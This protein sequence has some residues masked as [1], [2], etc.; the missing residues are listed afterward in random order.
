MRIVMIGNGVAATTAAATIRRY[1]TESS[2]TM[3][4]DESTPFYSRPR[5][6]EY[7]AG[8]A[9][10]EKIVIRDSAW[11]E[12]NN[13]ALLRGAKVDRVDS[14]H[15]EVAG[16]F[17]TI[18]Y[19]ALLIASGAAPALPAFFVPG[20]EDVFTLRTKSD[21]DAII[22]EAARVGSAT[23]IGGGLL[24]I[25]TANAL[26][27]RG[28][29]PT[30]V[31]YFDR[32]LPKQLDAEAA[33]I[34]QS[35]LEAKG[36]RILLGKTTISIARESGG[37]AARFADGSSLSGGMAVVSAGVRPNIAFLRDSGLA[38]GRG[39]IVDKRMRTSVPDIYA[40]GD[41][42][43]FQ[44]RL[45]GIWPAAKEQGEVAGMSIAGQASEYRGSLMSARL[46]VAGIDVASMGDIALSPK[47]RVESSRDGTSFR[48][49]FYEGDLLK[50]AILIGAAVA[51]QFRLQREMGLPDLR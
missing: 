22:A 38:L 32:L 36:L 20:L 7:L 9:N 42:A 3:L 47:T 4:S 10:F 34:L 15:R 31:E 28:L 46:K 29:A 24:G 40:A 39:I 21:A 1:D 19:D 26:A 51:D 23:V 30:V 2:V 50:G 45:Y 5:L 8:T 12:K 48:K 37:V 35:M 13:I 25:E 41:C 33:A 17:G 43:E 6:I 44:G 27:A 16:N 11:Y 14:A 18:A 49:L